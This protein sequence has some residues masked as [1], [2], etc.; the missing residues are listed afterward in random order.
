M[1]REIPGTWVGLDIGGA[2]IKI[3]DTAGRAS[4]LDFPL[5]KQPQHLAAA[6]KKLLRDSGGAA[7]IAVTMTGE[8]CHPRGLDDAIENNMR[9]RGYR[10]SRLPTIASRAARRRLSG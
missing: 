4:A 6:L 8:S 10:F 2:N 3:A 1:A 7:K 5:W 9:S